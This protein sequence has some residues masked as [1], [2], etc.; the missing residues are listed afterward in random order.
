MLA[1][2]ADG[3]SSIPNRVGFIVSEIPESIFFLNCS[4]V[5]YPPVGR[6]DQSQV[7]M[8][9]N[10]PETP[11]SLIDGCKGTLDWSYKSANQWQWVASIQPS[12]WEWLNASIIRWQNSIHHI[13]QKEI[14]FFFFFFKWFWDQHLSIIWI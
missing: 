2:K 14:W 11:C 13:K 5:P 9:M 4:S 8:E 1:H 3:L 12:N 6:W 7:Q 10:N